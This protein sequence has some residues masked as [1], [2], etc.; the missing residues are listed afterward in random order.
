MGSVHTIIEASPFSCQGLVREVEADDREKLLKIYTSGNRPAST[1]KTSHFYVGGGGR[2]GGGTGLPAGAVV[3]SLQTQVRVEGTAEHL[4]F[5]L[6]VNEDALPVVKNNNEINHGGKLGGG[7]SRGVVNPSPVFDRPA[8]K[9]SPVARDRTISLRVDDG[10]ISTGSTKEVEEAKS[11]RPPSD[12]QNQKYDDLVS[13]IRYFC[14][15]HRQHCWSN[16]DPAVIP[17]EFLPVNL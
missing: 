13:R 17:E 2:I 10:S 7:D 1:H 12:L 5:I 16:P 8:G 14:A 3:E 11:Q 15:S 6:G 4:F 9:T